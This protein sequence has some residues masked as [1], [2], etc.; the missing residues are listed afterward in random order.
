MVESIS[1]RFPR[2][3]PP[4]VGGEALQ[5]H[6]TR[7][8]A[9]LFL[10]CQRLSSPGERLAESVEQD[11]CQGSTAVKGR[12]ASQLRGSGR[13]ARQA[14]QTWLKLFDLWLLPLTP[15]PSLD[16]SLSHHPMQAAPGRTEPRANQLRTWGAPEELTIE[17]HPPIPVSNYARPSH[18]CS[19]G[20]HS[21]LSMRFSR[22]GY[23]SG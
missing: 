10:C 11:A 5:D 9:C 2:P 23:W 6:R 18:P 8:K 20:N 1:V 12:C 19:P 4:P 15:A 17:T 3:S 16:P 14:Q 7:Q 13:G 22:Q 21:S